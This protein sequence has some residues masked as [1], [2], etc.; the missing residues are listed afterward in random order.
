[1]TTYR[2]SAERYDD[3]KEKSTKGDDLKSPESKTKRG[4]EGVEGEAKD[5]KTEEAPAVE[6]KKR[7][8]EVDDGDVDGGE[9]KKAKSSEVE[10]T[11]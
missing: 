7:A 10:A 1:M 6:S 8:R 9:L 5:S 2:A 3:E 4:R 11:A